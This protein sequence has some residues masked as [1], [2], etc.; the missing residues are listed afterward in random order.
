MTPSM[1]K[2]PELLEVET[3]LKTATQKDPTLKVISESN[4]QREM[5]FVLSLLFVSAIIF[6]GVCFG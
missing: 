6:E 3:F 2:P 1:P 4:G 5:T